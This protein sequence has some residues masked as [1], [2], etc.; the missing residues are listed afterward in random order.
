MEV[1]EERGPQLT[2]RPKILVLGKNKSLISLLFII[3]AFKQ[4]VRV[5][6]CGDTQ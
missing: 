1:G 6:I 4:T 2:S 5:I 3:W